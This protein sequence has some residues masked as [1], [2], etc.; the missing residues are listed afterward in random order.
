LA[1]IAEAG[2]ISIVSKIGSQLA[3]YAA[4]AVYVIW[5]VGMQKPVTAKDG[6][7]GSIKP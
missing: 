7:P 6:P 5:V 1:A 4:A 2:R 3:F